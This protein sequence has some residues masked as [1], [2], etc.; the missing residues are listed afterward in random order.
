VVL[1]N[2]YHLL[3][4]LTGAVVAGV[5]TD[6]DRGIVLFDGVEFV[7][8]VNFELGFYVVPD[9]RLYPTSTSGVPSRK[10]IRSMSPSA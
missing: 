5:F 8:Q 7:M 4:Q 3:K 10:T 2:F 9:L 6:V 1:F